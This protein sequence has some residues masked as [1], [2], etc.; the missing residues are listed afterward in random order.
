MTILGV[1]I[2]LVV[3]LFVYLRIRDSADNNF[4]RARKHHELGQKYYQD[5]DQEEADVHYEI[6]KQYREKA[7]SQKTSNF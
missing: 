6:A 7:V 4:R 3:L 1:A 5:G 2:G